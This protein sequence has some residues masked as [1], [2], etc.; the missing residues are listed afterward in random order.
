MNVGIILSELTLTAQ[1]IDWNAQSD[2][3]KVL[4]IVACVSMG[5]FVLRTILMLIGCIGIDAGDGWVDIDG[6]GIPDVP[7]GD[8]LSDMAGLNLFSVNAVTAGLAIGTWAGY[9]SAPYVP[10]WADIIISVAAILA[11]MFLYAVIMRAIYRLQSN[12]TLQISNA[13]GKEGTVYLTVPAE[14]TGE[15]KVNAVVQNRYCEFEAV[16]DSRTKIVTGSRIR[17]VGVTG[18]DVVVVEPAG[19]DKNKENQGGTQN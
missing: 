2:L 11:I 6:D 1:I 13:I 18:S 5:I 17:I 12:G 19:D 3:Q 14:R 10:L 16:T 7:A 4:F 8:S 9:F 15:G